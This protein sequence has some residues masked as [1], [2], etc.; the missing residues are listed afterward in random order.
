V[1]F[2]AK[3]GSETSITQTYSGHCKLASLDRLDALRIYAYM[4]TLSRDSAS[5]CEKFDVYISNFGSNNAEGNI[6]NAVVN[7]F[8]VLCNVEQILIIQ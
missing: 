6:T 4:Y 2:Q 7:K 1:L 8:K 5:L 3:D